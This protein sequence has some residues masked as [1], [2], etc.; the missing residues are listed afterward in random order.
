MQNTFY[1]G[2]KHFRVVTIHGSWQIVLKVTKYLDNRSSEE[3]FNE[4]RVEILRNKLLICEYFIYF[5]D[6]KLNI[7]GL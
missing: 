7:F 6:S 2:L 3:L 4:N 1:V 5:S